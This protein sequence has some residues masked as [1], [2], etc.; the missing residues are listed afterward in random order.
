M[1]M[2]NRKK[3]IGKGYMWNG[4]NYNILKKSKT[5]ETLKRS[6]VARDR[7]VIMHVCMHAQCV[8]LRY[9]IDCSHQ[10]LSMEFSW[11]EYWIGLPFPPP[12]NLP[13]PGM[14]PTSPESL[15]LAG[16]LFMTALPWN[17][18]YICPNT[19][20]TQQQE[21]NLRETMAVEWLWYINVDS[22]LVIMY[23]SGEWCW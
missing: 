9:H 2:T 1:H 13:V 20:N 22:S 17:S 4:S 11:Q 8:W 23:H 14:Q 19:Q 7:Y 10:A 18:L 12:G 15:A 3:T 21:G 6:V 16:V 5:M